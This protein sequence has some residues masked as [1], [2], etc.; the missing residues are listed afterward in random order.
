MNQT[1]DILDIAEEA[2]RCGE[3]VCTGANIHMMTNSICM[4]KMWCKFVKQDMREELLEEEGID[5]RQELLNAIDRL[6]KDTLKA[7]K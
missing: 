2:I 6:R 5:D 4:V 3:K 7:M 1:Q